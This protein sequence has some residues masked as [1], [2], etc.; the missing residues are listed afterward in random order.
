MEKIICL[1]FLFIF[2]FVFISCDENNPVID[3]PVI[4]DIY[5]GVKFVIDTKEEVVKVKENTKVTKPV[6]PEKVGFEFIG[7]FTDDTLYDFESL[8]TKDI[9]IEAVWDLPIS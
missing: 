4:D 6:D 7:W 8:V 3:N 5:Y 9:T 2:S 1:L